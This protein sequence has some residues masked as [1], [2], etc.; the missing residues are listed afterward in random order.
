MAI[1]LEYMGYSVELPGGDTVVGRDVTCSLRFNDSAISRRHLRISRE[2]GDVFVE[3]L[4]S[5]NGTELNGNLIE[6]RTQVSDRDTIRV[7]E[8]YL[9]V[10]F[11][12]DNAD[13]PSTRRL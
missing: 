8:H 9:Q 3:D 5:T 4:G 13:Q 11:T 2:G 10:R 12:D 6:G 1:Y 7:G